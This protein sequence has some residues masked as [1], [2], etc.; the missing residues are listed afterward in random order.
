MILEKFLNYSKYKLTWFKGGCGEHCVVICNNNN[1]ILYLK[2]IYGTCTI[3]GFGR[4]KQEARK[5]L[6][7]KI[8]GRTICFMTGNEKTEILENIE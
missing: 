4:S 1:V 5:N 2:T 8:K 7:E 6:I 3:S